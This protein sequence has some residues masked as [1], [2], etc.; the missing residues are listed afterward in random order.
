MKMFVRTLF[1]TA[2]AT[3]PVISSAQPPTT[4]VTRTQVESE[5]SQLE[6][7]GYSIAGSDLDYPDSIESAEARLAAQLEEAARN[8]AMQSGY[9]STINGTSNSGA[10]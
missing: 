3:L 1:I 9:G 4:S 5:L 10:R 8:R 7:A 2:V 6:K